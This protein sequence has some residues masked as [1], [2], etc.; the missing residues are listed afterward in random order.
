MQHD[1]HPIS[2]SGILTASKTPV[3]NALNPAWRDTVVH[4]IASRSWDASLPPAQVSELVNDMTYNKLNAL[5]M[6]D[7]ASGAYLNE[8]C[9]TSFPHEYYSPVHP[10]TLARQTFLNPIG[11]GPFSDR[12]MEV[13][14]RSRL[15]MIQKIYSGAVNV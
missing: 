15:S 4:L 6:L 1:A 2:L 14:M 10:L 13:Y 11:N 5:R 8:A 12:T 3:D 7:P 9:Q